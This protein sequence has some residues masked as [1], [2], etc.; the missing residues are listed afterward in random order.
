MNPTDIIAKTIQDNVNLSTRGLAREIALALS[1]E[2]IVANAIA[3][4]EAEGRTV[5][6]ELGSTVRVVLGSVGGS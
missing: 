1:H 2:R 4:L 6:P 3:R 5:T